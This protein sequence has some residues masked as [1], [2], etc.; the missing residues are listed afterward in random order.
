MAPIDPSGPRLEPALNETRLHA[1]CCVPVHPGRLWLLGNRP[2]SCPC[3]S[4]S[5]CS[6]L[7]QMQP[8]PQGGCFPGPGHTCARIGSSPSPATEAGSALQ[9]LHVHWRCP[10]ASQDWVGGEGGISP[11]PVL[12]RASEAAE[13]A[14]KD[15]EASGLDMTSEG[16]IVFMPSCHREPNNAHFTLFIQPM[17]SF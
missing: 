13:A 4:S 10:P 6:N 3:R 8:P 5:C 16:G 2:F 9:H 11:Q 15:K 14:L 1:H 7:L 12:R 17:C